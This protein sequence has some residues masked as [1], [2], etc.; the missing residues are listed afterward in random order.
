MTRRAAAI[1]LAAGKGTRMKSDLP[2]VLHPVAGMPMIA[3]LLRELRTTD[4]ARIAVV[5]APGMA[6][7][8]SVVAPAPC[9]VQE[10]ALGTGHAV[11]AARDL[12]K[13]FDG[14]VLI[15]FGDTPLLTGDT[16]RS[17]VE[18][19]RSE[20]DPAVVVLGFRPDDAAEYGRLVV[21]DGGEL[22]RIVEFR[23]ATPEQ[24]EIGLCNAGIMAVDGNRLFALLDRVGNDNAKGEYYLTDIVAIA[25]SEG[26]NCAVVEAASPEEVAGVNSRAELAAAEA[27]MQRRLRGKAMDGG[28]TL[29]DPDTVYFSGDTVLG[30]DVVVGPNVFFGPGVT[31]G[32]NVTIRAFCHIEGADVRSGA[33]VGPFARLRPGA[34][35]GEEVHIGNFVEIKAAEVETGA[36]VNHLSYVGDARVGAGANVG[37]GTITCNYDGVAKHRTEIGDG[38]FIGSNSAL[39][40][41]VKIGNSAYVGSGSVIT[42]DVPAEAL[43]IGRGRQAVKEG[44]VARLRAFKTAKKK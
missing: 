15:L 32:D 28:A 35:I 2:K 31:V 12:M 6:D 11:M 4:V 29:I 39:V 18:A 23:D 26:W 5:V 25:R 14:D 10:E 22:Q 16:I 41:P 1:V 21:G 34:R 37:A 7:V 19:R 42:K 24:R 44:W 27:A 8:A 38:A 33:I 43:A 20:G 13:G 3:L 17:M 9:A 40:A 30:R 36:K